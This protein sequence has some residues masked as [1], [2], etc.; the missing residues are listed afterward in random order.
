MR[1]YALVF[2]L[3]LA[4]SGCRTSSPRPAMVGSPALQ[5]ALAW[6]AR[7]E[8]PH[9]D[10]AASWARCAAS[11]W[12]AM[13]DADDRV[14]AEAAALSSLCTDRFLAHEVE[15]SMSWTEGRQ[16]FRGAAMQVDFREL[17]P[18]TDGTLTLM[19][20]AD[21]PLAGLEG[22]QHRTPGFGTPLA[23]LAPRCADRPAC[24]LF[25]PEGIFRWATAWFEMDQATGEPIPRLVIA[26]PFKVGPVFAGARELTLATD[27]TAFLARGIRRS[28]LERLAI[29]GLIGGREVGRR[30]GL[31][32]LEDYDPRKRPIVMIHGLGSSPLIWAKLSNAIWADPALRERYQVWHVVYQTNAP[33]LVAH[34]RVRGYL[35]DAW[36]LLDPD[37]N[38]PARAGMVLVGHSLG[39]VI[40]RLMCVH[41][42]EVL[43]NASFTVPPALLPG[44]P[45]DVAGIQ[46]VFLFSPYPGVSRA[47]F[48]ATPHRGSPTAD[49][50]LGR[51]ARV[52]VGRRVPEI[53]ALKR[54][55]RAHPEVVQEVVRPTYQRAFVNSISTLQTA[56]PV[57]R[58]GQSLLPAPH[59]AYHVIS[60]VDPSQGADTD[61][62]VPLASS[63]LSGAEST[64]VVASAHDVYDNDLAI[65][66][67]LRILAGAEGDRQEDPT[68]DPSLR[69]TARPG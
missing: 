48:L 59:I 14:S 32:L 56:Q 49:A 57:R 51:L 16:L 34:R 13:S 37:G 28:K 11:A 65:A 3:L 35:D 23:T 66:E 18:D 2:V 36:R 19:R 54:V 25:P 64:L 12:L 68:Q 6:Q 53:Q 31:Y 67:V 42:G 9:R 52:L 15:A 41:S 45:E 47:I 10:R 55:S 39:G 29:F 44:S 1:P 20:A 26:D 17:S 7:A 21:V 8:H 50:W 22:Y 60:G 4:A 43:W 46:D 5:Q 33:L 27:T 58:A 61:G 69:P 40:S 24:Q 38:D 30:S 62:V 63:L